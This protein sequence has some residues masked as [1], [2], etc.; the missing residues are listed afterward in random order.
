[1]AGVF[2]EG[3]TKDRALDIATAVLGGLALPQLVAGGLP[4]WMGPLARLSAQPPFSTHSGLMLLASLG[5]LGGRIW[6]RHS[7]GRA[8]LAGV[9]T[10]H[11]PDYEQLDPE[12]PM[13]RRLIKDRIEE[14]S[15]FS[16]PDVIDIVDEVLSTAIFLGASDV[17]LEAKAKLM[18]VSYRVDGI[19][20]DVATVPKN[21]HQALVNRLK[22][23]SQLDI[24]KTDV[25]QD[26]RVSSR[27]RGRNHNMR[28]S[29]FPTLHGETIVIRILGSTKK[30]YN[31]DDFGIQ[32]DVLESFKR[33]LHAPQGI[34]LFTGP[35]GSGKTSLMYAALREILS[36]EQAKRNICTLEDP[37]E[38]DLE[39]INQA[40]IDPKKG[41]TFAVGLRAILRQDPDIIM[42]GEIRDVETAQVALQAGQTG[43]M[44]ISTVHA[45]SAAGAFARLIDMGIEPFLLA[46]SVSGIVAQRLV[47]KL[48]Q[49]CLVQKP[50][51]P[52]ILRS[53]GSQVPAGLR[54]YEAGG[55]EQCNGTGFRG[56][57]AIFEF[58]KVSETI[59]NSMMTKATSQELLRVARQDG[60]LTLFE[61]GMVK[62]AQ[63]LTSL[64]ELVR[65]VV[66]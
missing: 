29:V 11:R 41:V 64:E 5:A 26:G 1:M 25:P 49:S 53:L 15:S 7:I 61:D 23:M 44:I 3:G 30:I 51:K 28:I 6:L 10:L 39:D 24:S 18:K 21:I 14:K 63:G 8:E 12:D 38:Q 31:L 9:Q 50:P 65:V 56:R 13:V 43:H 48:C 19:L 33:V 4:D 34:I 47:R 58:M 2:E 57:L 22:I 46:S 59:S 55:C 32:T 54:F 27:I 45:N 40:Q 42:V 35:T 60:M 62:V 17:H 16:D 52:E 20:T 36:A 66:G 37:I